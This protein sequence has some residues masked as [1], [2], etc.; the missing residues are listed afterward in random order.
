VVSLPRI[1]IIEELTKEPIAP[2]SNLLVEFDPASQWYNASL[3]IAAGWIKTGGKADYNVSFE[4]PDVL[5]S[6]LMRL[7]LKVEEVEHDGRLTI[8]DFYTVTLGKK[9]GEKVARQT[10]KVSEMSIEWSRYLAGPQTPELLRIVDTVS[11]LSRYNE[12][13][14]WVEFCITRSLAR[15]PI[16]KATWLAGVTKGLH[17]PWVYK[18]LESAHDGIIDLDLDTSGDEP[19]NMIRIRTLRNAHFDGRWHHLKIGENFE[20]ILEE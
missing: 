7:G 18:Q 20:T 4:P 2:G 11:T 6:Q 13:K 9:S 14:A 12:D 8:D 15:S 17:E 5:R 3:T 10:L 1:P 16:V 19:R